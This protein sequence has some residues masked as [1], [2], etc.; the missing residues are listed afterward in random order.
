MLIFCFCQSS[1]KKIIYSKYSIPPSPCPVLF[2]PNNPTR[3]LIAYSYGVQYNYRPAATAAIAPTWGAVAAPA[4]AVGTYPGVFGGVGPVG[5][6]GVPSFAGGFTGGFN[7][8][9]AGVPIGGSIPAMMTR[10]YGAGGAGAGAGAAVSS[11]K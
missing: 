9:L 2:E 10:I 1:L 11:K 4:M 5:G 3:F 7:N 6:V 8:G